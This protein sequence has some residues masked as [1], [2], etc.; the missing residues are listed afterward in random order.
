MK[1]K[2]RTISF[3]IALV[4][5][6]GIMNWPTTSEA[7]RYDKFKVYITQ[8][9]EVGGSVV[10]KESVY[11]AA[12]PGEGVVLS[13]EV[14]KT[15]GGDI[16]YLHSWDTDDVR[17]AIDKSV[18]ITNSGN[19]TGGYAF[20]GFTMPWNDVRITLNYNTSQWTIK[21]NGNILKTY[22]E[23][24]DLYGTI[25]VP[26]NADNA[27]GV[28]VKSA[29]LSTSVMY[30]NHDINDN[31]TI[32][33]EW[34]VGDI[35]FDISYGSDKTVSFH[36]GYRAAPINLKHGEYMDLGAMIPYETFNAYEELDTRLSE[37]IININKA[38]GTVEE[39]R[40]GVNDFDTYIDYGDFV[41]INESNYKVISR[42]LGM[43]TK[44]KKFKYIMPMP[45]FGGSM[46]P[47]YKPVQEV[48]LYESILDENND[49]VHGSEIS[50]G[51]LGYYIPGEKAQF[52]VTDGEK[53]QGYEDG[54]KW[55]YYNI[56]KVV[57]HVSVDN[58]NANVVLD[59][60]LFKT[61]E[62]IVPEVS[63]DISVIAYY[64]ITQTKD[65]EKSTTDRLSKYIESKGVIE[66]YEPGETNPVIRIDSKDIQK[67]RDDINELWRGYEALKRKV[68]GDE[69]GN[70]KVNVAIFKV[71]ESNITELQEK[72]GN[73][74]TLE[75]GA[76]YMVEIG[77]NHERLY[78]T[79]I[80]LAR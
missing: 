80:L 19:K 21:H 59:N 50:L 56:D 60:E 13:T 26:I 71:T 10:M 76:T 72:V 43:T 41:E 8:P 49:E 14:K 74:L 27:K 40:V 69:N 63:S 18:M 65:D 54:S 64:K 6:V 22:S 16:L 12:T 28:M 73:T 46:T 4:I 47:I 78:H 44:K 3:I 70:N 61:Y 23:V 75:I 20:F 24:S 66:V 38:D 48:T 9:V 1:T 7:R 15:L 32:P 37:L 68:N 29:P 58:V 2:T 42:N 62:F 79:I 39:K 57:D 35:E 53:Y 52:S 25:Q 34:L 77:A 5:I 45:E 17:G 36:N 11:R 33:R 67:N 31:F 55:V 51:S 30:T